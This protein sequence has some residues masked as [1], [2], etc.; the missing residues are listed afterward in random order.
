METKPRRGGK[1]R[2]AT[3]AL[4]MVSVVVL[5]GM[6][7][8]T[9]DVGMMY[10]ARGEAQAAADAAAM[11]GAWRL[12]DDESL[13]GTPDMSEEI[14]WARDTAAEYAMKNKIVNE[15]P[16][17]DIAS[18]VLVGRLNNPW[19]PN[20]ELSYTNPD[21]YNTV[22][23][24]VR[25]DDLR[26]GPID[27]FFAGIFGRATA[28]V[29]AEAYAALRNDVGGFRP[30]DESGNSSLL[31]FTLHRTAWE[32][33]LDGT[34]TSGDNY[35][36]NEATGA[37]TAG[38]DGVYELNIYPGGGVGALPP[39]NLG[40]LD[41]GEG[42]NSAAD[43]ARQILDGISADDLTA[44]G[45]ELMLGPDGTLILNGDTGLSAGVSNELAS[46]IGLPRTIPLFSSV[47]GPGNNA[48]FTIVGFAGIR[49]M[50]VKLTGSMSSKKV[51][52]QP[53]F[54]IDGSAVVAGPGVV[55]GDGDFVYRPVELIR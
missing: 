44:L 18:D 32:N 47:V 9:V 54:V 12:L 45:G 11:A 43:L 34:F 48:N 15:G 5:I 6:A 31:P 39:G 50:Y 7:S 30:T 29:T 26:N 27:L 22:R 13:A 23:V 35:S 1:R 2:G 52:I 25:R 20:E 46:I 37:V 3:F 33:L 24:L 41:I 14:V 53:A 16:A 17:V 21:T 36:Y 28:D 19:D 8:L 10:R 42:G 49:I 4:I 51:I 38:A 40:T 55:P